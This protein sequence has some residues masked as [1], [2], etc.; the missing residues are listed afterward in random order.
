MP[1][2]LTTAV[3]ATL[4]AMAIP[5]AAVLLC[6]PADAADYKVTTCPQDKSYCTQTTKPI[7]SAEE[8]AQIKEPVSVVSY[9]PA[10][11]AKKAALRYNDPGAVPLCPLPYEM[12][13]RDGCR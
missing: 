1:K 4:V 6:G 2:F 9:K 12:T 8:V 3:L 5:T 11:E 10:A 13:P 7:L